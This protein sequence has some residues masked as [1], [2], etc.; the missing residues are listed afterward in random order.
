VAGLEAGTDA[1][2]FTQSGRT[3]S[4]SLRYTFVGI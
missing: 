3:F 2:L 1:G 4:A